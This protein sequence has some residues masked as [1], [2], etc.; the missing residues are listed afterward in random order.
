MES[1][2]RVSLSRFTLH[3]G[4]V[5]DEYLIY[6]ITPG[7]GSRLTCA[8]PNRGCHGVEDTHNAHNCWI[9]YAYLI[10]LYHVIPRF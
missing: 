5:D 10:R 7:V 1:D 4:P 6:H 8:R 2:N 3:F 9:H